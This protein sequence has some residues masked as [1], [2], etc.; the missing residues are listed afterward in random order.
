MS[1]GLLACTGDIT[2]I[3]TSTDDIEQA[4][5]LNVGDTIRLATPAQR[6]A[7]I[8]RQHGQCAAPGCTHTH[9]EIHHTT[10][11][12]RG[13]KTDLD[14]LIGICQNC[15][16]LVHRGLLVIEALGQGTFNLTTRD[17]RPLNLQQRRTTR[18]HL[19]HI[20]RTARHTRDAQEYPLRA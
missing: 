12:S 14:G 18:H 15:H 7:V 4:Q 11:W 20:R 16:S 3:L 5:V 13:G 1:A 17:G 8:A 10:W 6:K 2:P 9:L 19:R